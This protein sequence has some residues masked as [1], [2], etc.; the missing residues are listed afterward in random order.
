MESID[1]RNQLFSKKNPISHTN[2]TV[3]PVPTLPE[4]VGNDLGLDWDDTGLWAESRIVLEEF[5]RSQK[6]LGRGALLSLTRLIVDAL[7]WTQVHHRISIGP[8]NK[9]ARSRAA[10][11]SK[12]FF[13]RFPRSK[14]EREYLDQCDRE[15]AINDETRTQR[16]LAAYLENWQ[17]RLAKLQRVF[18]SLRRD[19]WRVPGK[20]EEEVRDL[21]IVELLWA[22]RNPYIFKLYERPG[23]EASFRYLRRRKDN[24]RRRRK[25]YEYTP[26]LIAQELYRAPETPEQVL[27]AKEAPG[28]AAEII[29][30]I[31]TGL[32]GN[33]SRWLS[34]MQEDVRKRGKL[35]LASVSQQLGKN[36]ASGS[37]A[38]RAIR[39]EF[40]RFQARRDN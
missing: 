15:R 37:R 11:A 38:F 19:G 22:I 39:A 5:L 18:P 33:R 6:M 7:E 8:F 30:E 24:L 12:R 17:K 26:K 9:L 31:K 29:E 34:A 23:E 32:S 25:I 14:L 3:E 21:L 16:H 36:R 28:S 20:T 10:A 27:I 1:G 2:Q 4:Q 40:E 35:N 13:A